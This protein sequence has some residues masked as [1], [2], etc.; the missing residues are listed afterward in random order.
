MAE[1]EEE[2]GEQ[3]KKKDSFQHG[4]GPFFLVKGMKRM[5]CTE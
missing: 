1:E 3:L 5:Q 2:G 4:V